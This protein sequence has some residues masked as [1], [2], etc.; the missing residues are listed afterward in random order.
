MAMVRLYYASQF[1]ANA[2][3]II[4]FYLH[5]FHHGLLGS[6]FLLVGIYQRI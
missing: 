3:S 4:R 1:L 6:V 2:Y 5:D